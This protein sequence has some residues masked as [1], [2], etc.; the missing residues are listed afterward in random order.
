[1]SQAK[2]N[3]SEVKQQQ[4]TPRQLEETPG[5][6]GGQTAGQSVG[7]QAALRRARVN[8]AALGAADL[9]AL[10][11]VVGNRKTQQL[12]VQRNGD[13]GNNQQQNSPAITA[14]SRP[15]VIFGIDSTTRRIYA[16]VTVPSHSIVEITQYLYEDSDKGPEL[17]ARNG[18]P[19]VVQGGRN[20]T[21]VE[22]RLT[23][24]ANQAIQQ[25]L[26]SGTILRTDGVPSGDTDEAQSS[27]YRFNA[28]GQAFELT[29]GQMRGMLQ[30][31]GHWI[32]RKAD[33]I[34][35]LA[36]GGREVHSDHLENTNSWVRGISDWMA[37]QDELPLSVWEEALR[38]SQEVLDTLQN[39]NFNRL[40]IADGLRIIPQQARR[41]ENAATAL[42][43][44]E[45]RWHRYI[46]GTISGAG[47]AVHRLEI[48]RNV[49]FSVAA[50]L[51]GA[52]VAPAVF[53]AAGTS[54]ATAG[55]T[56]T[57]ATVLSGTAAVGTGAVAGG[58]LQGALNVIAPGAQ[59]ERAVDERFTAGFRQGALSGGLGAA[60]AL[61]A[62]GVSGAISQR[63]YGV[64]PEALTSL[65][66]R[67]A[68]GAL[69]GTTL[70][71]P[72]GGIGAV[73]TNVGALVR[74]EITPAQYLER[75]GWSAL[76]G[77]VF[78]AVFGFL[79]TARGRSP[80][81][82]LSR[83]GTGRG[84]SAVEPDI[85]L[86][87]PQVNPQTGTVSQML[88]HRPTGQIFQA[89]YNPTT[90]TGQ[91]INLST[92]QQ[93]GVFNS[94]QIASPA[95]GLLPAS[96]LTP[97]SPATVAMGTG[98]GSIPGRSPIALPSP[99]MTPSPITGNT[100]P[101]SAG[102]V[103]GTTTLI[104]PPRA[105]TDIRSIPQTVQTSGGVDVAI[106]SGRLEHVL[107]AHTV[108]NFDPVTRAAEIAGQ[109]ATHL[110]TFFRPGT[111]TNQREL[112]TLIRQAL[113]GR[114]G[115]NLVSG[116]NNQIRLTLRNHQVETWIGPAS[117][118]G[119]RMNSIYPL[120]STGRN[121]T[122]AQI[123]AY[124]AELTAGSKTI[125]QIRAEVARLLQ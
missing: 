68:V 42:D 9:L 16:S 99:A 37:D 107:R 85:I 88:L 7:P 69:T 51:A 84:A 53:A 117:G 108:E 5:Q 105:R 72:L 26:T 30:G 115:R 44:A 101:V 46:E 54:L 61:A 65:G 81:T 110:T 1:M 57:T 73:I 113:Q 123:R 17:Q 89:T 100:P 3:A 98:A 78:G 87:P 18:V 29:E 60:G 58:T 93:V 67:A 39:A 59:A 12:I 77:A 24:V 48:V 86:N 103:S 74:G 11:R 79:G 106:E 62:P 56:G 122:A 96:T 118:G 40:A 90:G 47:V 76:Q 104:S 19:D 114:A 97:S 25:A 92:G 119:M 120:A 45:R 80:S 71:A 31:L 20:L 64:A 49:S 33:Y 55:V 23:N 82:A 22:G 10:Q 13:S 4:R 112:F 124:A 15:P 8:P 38:A 2:A 95:A 21:L 52:A 27:V 116:T 28:A 91:I 6:R 36:E 83:P 66:S 102:A 109:P 94:G 75:I 63:L 121:L 111:V 70:G 50:G 34:H 14:T 35:G 43:N 125:D 41:L 32:R